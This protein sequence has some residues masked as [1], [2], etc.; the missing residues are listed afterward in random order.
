MFNVKYNNIVIFTNQFASM[1]AANLPLIKIFDS[2]S[3]EK[4][5]KR[6]L[7]VIKQIKDSVV[8]GTDLGVA[9][10]KHPK[11]FNPIYVNMV[12]AGIASGELAETL[13]HLSQYMEKTSE[14]KGKVK[15]ALT[16]P[17]F[18][19]CFL[20]FVSGIMVFK[21]LPMFEE[22]FKKSG[23]EMPWLTKWFL[24]FSHLVINNFHIGLIFIIFIIFFI[25]ILLKTNSGRLLWDRFKLNIIIF[26]DLMKKAAIAKFLRTFSTLIQNEVNI[27][28]SLNLV[29]SSADNK[30]LELKLKY[31][32]DLIERGVR[33][34]DAFKNADFFPETVLQM[35]SSGEE[36]GNIDKLL[37]NAANFYDAQVDDSV[38]SIV[39]LINPILTL[40]IGSV[41]AVMIIALYLPIIQGAF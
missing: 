33:I 7:S 23:K 32:R 21:I 12:N 18:M 4:M 5:N 19:L 6:L 30:F 25:I 35:I 40:F 20:F 8:N 26:G 28:D 11:I 3:S 22:M 9:F 2:L 16:Y 37:I 31:I 36:T 13:K 39:S 15:S 24:E 38:K 10:A 1:Y 29:F 17:I 34:S 27:I 41:V 14:V